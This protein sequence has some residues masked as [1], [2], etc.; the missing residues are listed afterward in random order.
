MVTFN[1]SSHLRQILSRIQSFSWTY[2]RFVII[3]NASEDGTSEVLKEFR[4]SLNL[5]IIALPENIGH[6]AGLAQGLRRLKGN[7]ERPDYVVF[8][9]DDSFPQAEYLNYLV[10]AIQK[11][12]FTLISSGGFRVKLG[13]RINLSPKI[14]EVLTADFGLFDGAIARF[15]DLMQV[16]Y[17]VEDWFMMVDDFEYCYRIKKE[18]FMIGVVHNPYVEIRHE[19][20][21]GTTS[22]SPLW[23]SYYQSRNFVHFVQAHLS[24]FTFWDAVILNSKRL[25]GGVFVKNGWKLIRLRLMGFRAGFQGKKGKSL[26]LKTLREVV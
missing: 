6:G 16:G 19:G 3:N 20:W 8:L 21:V 4:V 7:G 12:M 17:P 1:R 10:E 23:R 2:S 15:E 18:G 22:T 5:E 9:E 11:H 24:W 25:V 26:D 13:K 14:G